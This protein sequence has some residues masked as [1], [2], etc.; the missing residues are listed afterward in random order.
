MVSRR[1]Q[2]L[3]P[4]RQ[5]F[6]VLHR[7]AQV[8]AV[9]IPP[10]YCV[11]AQSS[12][13]QKKAVKEFKSVT[14][15]RCGHSQPVACSLLHSPP[16]DT[17][18][19]PLCPFLL[20]P[21]R[22]D[23]VA[24]EVLSS[25]AWNLDRALDHFFSHRSQFPSSSSTSSPSSKADPAKLNRLFDAYADPHDKDVMAGEHLARF[26]TDLSIDPSSLHTLA[27]AYTLRCRSFGEIHRSELVPHYTQ[28]GIDSV[29]RIKQHSQ[30]AVQGVVKD[31]A[32]MKQFARW[33]FDFVKEEGERKTI[34]ADAAVEM[35]GL[36]L[37]RWPL[38]ADW[39]K[40]VVDTAKLKV[41]SQ[42]LWMQ[43]YDFSREVGEDL[44]KFDADGAW[45]VIIDDFVEHV[46]V[47]STQQRC[48][49]SSQPPHSSLS[50]P[51]PT[52]SVL[53]CCAVCCVAEQGWQR[54]ERGEE[55]KP[56]TL[57]SSMPCDSSLC[58]SPSCLHTVQKWRIVSSYE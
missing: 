28:L 6:P 55:V 40:F 12:A 2:P 13:A 5:V 37:Q 27:Y 7:R 17:L 52:R 57:L 54:Q 20:C 4:T 39:L 46:K 32:Q 14:S 38:C 25:H 24:A 53:R 9:H 15:A 44:S 35:W 51:P 58:L 43:L 31:D 33:L 56:H 29:E 8:H 11:A 18:L 48:V 22:S 49:A 1:L 19:I 41:V 23:K 50:R 34:D 16:S 10:C 42:D 26:F 21:L 47:R 36:L 30:Q 3:H 45:P